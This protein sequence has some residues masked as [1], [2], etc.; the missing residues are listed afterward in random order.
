[1]RNPSTNAT[2]ASTMRCSHVYGC[3]GRSSSSSSSSSKSSSAGRPALVL[4]D[5]PNGAAPNPAAG[6]DDSP[7]RGAGT[8]GSTDGGLGAADGVGTHDA[9]AASVVDA[10]ACHGTVA[11]PPAD[12]PGADCEPPGCHDAGLASEAGEVGCHDDAP[13]AEVD[14]AEVDGAGVDG[15]AGDGPADGDAP[16]GDGLP[17][18]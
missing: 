5:S 11:P 4:G 18:G 7:H 16:Q 2:R 6:A 13:G 15:A 8:V 10:D 17:V 3:F 1:M 12:D 9:G 14:G